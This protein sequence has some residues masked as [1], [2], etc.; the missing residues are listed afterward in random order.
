MDKAGIETPVQVAVIT[1]DWGIVPNL[2]ALDESHVYWT[3]TDSGSLFF[4]PKS[5]SA[6]ALTEYSRPRT[7]SSTR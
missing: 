6:R 3:T 5:Q 1:T 2:L 4:A 7:R